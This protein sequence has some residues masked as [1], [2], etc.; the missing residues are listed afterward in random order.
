MVRSL[1]R[2]LPAGTGL[3]AMIA[4]IA[5]SPGESAAKC[6][7]SGGCDP[8]FKAPPSTPKPTPRIVTTPHHET[9]PAPRTY[10]PPPA[11]SHHS[12]PN[13]PPARPAAPLGAAI[14]A[15]SGAVLG[16]TL[17]TARP[18]NLPD[19]ERLGPSDVLNS[20]YWKHG[21][22]P[23]VTA[24]EYPRPPERGEVVSPVLLDE[25]DRARRAAAAEA[26]YVAKQASTG[27]DSVDWDGEK[28]GAG[29]IPMPREV[30]RRLR[31]R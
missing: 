22:T 23:P 11:I 6:Y 15:A 8:V 2:I 31:E 30:V 19:N 13:T 12:A 5:V 28:P 29:K 9:P 3:L 14:G 10:T 16:S 24:R 21:S 17:G 20:D 27:P 1:R 4:V 25:A 18:Y 26:D 7:S